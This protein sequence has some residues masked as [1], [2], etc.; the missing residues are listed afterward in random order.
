[1]APAILKDTL[2][3]ANPA[4]YLTMSMGITFPLNIVLGIPVFWWIIQ[5]WL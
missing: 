5:N 1:V 2:P 4:K 3:E